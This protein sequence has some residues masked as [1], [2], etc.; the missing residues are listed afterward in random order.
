MLVVGPTGLGMERVDQYTG[1]ECRISNS[2]SPMDKVSLPAP[3]RLARKEADVI[4][5]LT[6]SSQLQV[7]QNVD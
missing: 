6:T 2:V 3:M 1:N 7:Y 4:K 5:S